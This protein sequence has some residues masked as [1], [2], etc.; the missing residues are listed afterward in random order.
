MNEYPEAPALASSGPASQ[1]KIRQYLDSEKFTAV[2]AVDL[3]GGNI[4]RSA[5]A[6]AIPY[7]TLHDWVQARDNRLPP[8]GDGSLVKER[9]GDLATKMESLL[10]SL[11][12][13]MPAKI[14][15]ATL[16]QTAVTT[17][18]VF[19]KLRIARGQGLEPDPAMEL[20]RLL[21][22]NRSQLPPTLKLEEGEE[23]PDEVIALLDLRKNPDGS[24]EVES[25]KHAEKCSD[26]EGEDTT[27]QR[28][29]PSKAELAH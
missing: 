9:R 28:D 4:H 12:E 22:I 26:R 29:R 14:E 15:K 3:N 24:F 2:A 27:E 7:R 8:F 25:T 17:G 5:I 1:R 18:I 10:H 13:A 11:V 16:S 23:I 6:L 20:C 19:D 21:G